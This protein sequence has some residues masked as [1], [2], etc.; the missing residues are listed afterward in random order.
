[1]FAAE[2]SLALLS[3]PHLRRLQANGF[4]AILPG[5]ESWYTCGGKSKT[6]RATGLEK[7]QRGSGHVN[8]ILR[9]SPYVQAHCGLG[10]HGE[11]GEEPFELT[12]R[13]VDLTPGV[14][15]AYSLLSAFGQAAPL[16]LELQREG[17]VLPTP[18]HFL[19]NNRAANVRPKNYSW[20]AFYE[21]VVGLRK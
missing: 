14:F 13:F 11:G 17:R 15:P 1:D 18:F 16:N 12:K 7:V 21:N 5:I 8:T 2:S 19:D 20:P 6:G 3:E 9:C 4:K 10:L